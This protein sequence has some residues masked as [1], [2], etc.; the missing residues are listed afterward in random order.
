MNQIFISYGAKFF[1][2][3]LNVLSDI[4]ILTKK[5]KENVNMHS[6]VCA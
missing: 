6:P 1:R 4:L 3:A 2:I 5:K